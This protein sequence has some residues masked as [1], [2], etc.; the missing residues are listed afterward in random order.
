M[1]SLKRIQALF[2]GASALEELFQVELS[3]IVPKVAELQDE[4]KNLRKDLQGA[5]LKA[6]L[7]DL[8]KYLASRINVGPVTLL[9]AFFTDLDVDLLRQVGDAMK[10]RV[11]SSLVLLASRSGNDLRL[12]AM[13][14]EKAVQQGAHAGKFI[15]EVAGRLGGSGGGRPNMAQAGVRT[16]VELGANVE[17][18]MKDSAAILRSQLGL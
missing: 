11:P 15:K 14:D 1:A 7:A 8:D 5:T 3:E 4:I 10:S 6:S 16:T 13:A 9:T 2:K 17:G 12:V 18:L